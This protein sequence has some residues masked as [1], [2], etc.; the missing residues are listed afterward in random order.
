VEAEWTRNRGPVV[1]RIVTRN[2]GELSRRVEDVRG[3]HDAPISEAESAAK[4][5]ECFRLG[6]RPLD[7][8]QI[9]MLTARVRGL[10][11]VPDMSTFLGGILST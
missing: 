9:E 8:A 6:A 3:G 7:E 1:V 5:R 4:F 11:K 10:E 2:H